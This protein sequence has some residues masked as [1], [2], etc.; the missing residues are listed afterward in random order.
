MKMR[1][2]N[3]RQKTV[4]TRAADQTLSLVIACQLHTTGGRRSFI[5]MRIWTPHLPGFA[6]LS[7]KSP[8][9]RCPTSV[10]FQE[11]NQQLRLQLSVTYRMSTRSIGCLM[12]NHSRNISQS[13]NIRLP[14]CATI[15]Q[16]I[17]YELSRRITHQ[18]KLTMTVELRTIF[19]RLSQFGTFITVLLTYDT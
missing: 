11:K 9:C 10:T 6:T 1:V 19:I 15:Q 5:V 7:S 2:K 17:A 3:T 13:S 4:V 14:L 12:Y 18:N 8:M 16:S